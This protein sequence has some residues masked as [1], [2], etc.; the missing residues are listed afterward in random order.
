MIRINTGARVAGRLAMAVAALNLAL[1]APVAEAAEVKLQLSITVTVGK[2]NLEPSARGFLTGLQREL[3]STARS[4]RTTKTD[5]ARLAERR[6]QEF[7]A[8]PKQ[9]QALRGAGSS[10]PAKAE[11]EVTLSITIKTGGKRLTP[12][13]QTFVRALERDLSLQVQQGRLSADAVPSAVEKAMGEY[14]AKQ[15]GSPS[16]GDKPDVTVGLSITIKF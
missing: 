2:K 14:A 8:D 3:E 4:R 6:V 10:E 7:E 13:D 15:A 5:L 9:R 16:W 1:V 12:Q 11:V